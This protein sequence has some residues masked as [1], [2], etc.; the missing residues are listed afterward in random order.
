MSSITFL[1]FLHFSRSSFPKKLQKRSPRCVPQKGHCLNY[2]RLSVFFDPYFPVCEKIRKI[3][4]RFLLYLSQ[5]G[6]HLFRRTPL[7]YCFWNI[8]K[9]CLLLFCHFTIFLEAVPQRKSRSSLP[10]VFFKKSEH[11]SRRTYLGD[12]FWNS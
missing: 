1:L 2:V 8:L 12:C 10:D 6:K 5:W 11:L 7:G 3:E 4:T 9:C